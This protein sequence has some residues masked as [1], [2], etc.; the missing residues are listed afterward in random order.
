MTSSRNQQERT[1][2]KKLPEDLKLFLPKNNGSDIIQSIVTRNP[3][4]I[5]VL[6][7]SKGLAAT[8]VYVDNLMSNHEQDQ[9]LFLA[10]EADKISRYIEIHRENL[11]DFEIERGKKIIQKLSNYTSGLNILKM[12]ASIAEIRVDANA[13]NAY[14][15]FLPFNNG[16]LNLETGELIPPAPEYL[17]TKRIRFDYVPGS[18]CPLWEK[19]V[20]EIGGHENGWV[21]KMQ[22]VMGSSLGAEMPPFTFFFI[23]NGENGKSLLVDVLQHILGDFAA[24][25]PSSAYVKKIRGAISNDQNLLSGNRVGFC[26]EV[27]AQ[28]TLDEVFVKATSGTRLSASRPLYKNIELVE[29]TATPF[30]T[31]NEMPYIV[32]RSNGIYRRLFPIYFKESFAGRADHN[33]FNKLISSE[34]S[35]ITGWLLAGYQDVK[36]NPL[37]QT[38]EMVKMLNHY[39]AIGDPISTFLSEM[40]VMDPEAKTRTSDIIAAYRKWILKHP[41]SKLLSNDMLTKELSARFPAHKHKRS[42]S[43]YLGLRLVGADKQL[44]AFDAESSDPETF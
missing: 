24:T 35:G 19:T 4:K 2:L 34:V 31:A 32:D 26:A 37:A 22:R 30:V 13:M 25:M 36:A 1:E 20:Y 8:F 14:P 3:N 41:E 42:E 16:I 39:M 6:S 17:F 44:D 43:Y 11:E 33:L 23:G 28:D 27:P 29:N 21:K 5:V 7:H 38:P 40:I 10:S 15:T 9:L 18:D 12:A